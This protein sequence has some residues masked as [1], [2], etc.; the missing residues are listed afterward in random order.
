MSKHMHSIPTRARQ[1]GV[2]LI[3]LMISLVLGLL[4]VGAAIG[5]F[6]TNKQTYR[7]TQSLGRVQENGQVAF[8]L[9]SRDIREAGATPCD[10]NMPPGNIIDGATTAAPD[11]AG[12]FFATAFPL[13]G[14]EGGGPAHVAGTDVIQ[15][16]RTG[17]D[18]RSSAADLTASATSV[19]YA[20]GNPGFKSG[21]PVMICDMKVLGVF[22]ANGDSTTGASGSVSF[23]AGTGIN[24]CGYF[25]Q[26]NAVACSDPAT[27][28]AF[29]KFATISSLQGIR[30]F[31]RDTDGNASNGYSLYRQVNG[32]A[33]EEV[34]QGVT[35]LQFRYLTDAGYVDAGSL[36][37]AAA[38]KNVRAVRM[39]LVLR[40]TETTGTDG[41]PI[42]R[43]IE[44][45]VTLRNRVL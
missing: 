19:T 5:V 4:V 26:P 29:P 23:D 6:A 7:A 34:V 12:W 10:V 21:D 36:A 16:L 13:F 28:Y 20:P 45:V 25:P 11:N 39:R 38:W 27:A 18:I 35:D 30:W 37:G 2:S 41:E 33:A 32:A 40:D 3:E 17:D 44:N 24:A 43:T 9:L 42:T 8:E 31:L 15:V 14:F 1:A 22:R